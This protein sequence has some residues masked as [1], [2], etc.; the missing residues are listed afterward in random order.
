RLAPFDGDL[1]DYAKWLAE[2]GRAAAVSGQQNAMPAEREAETAESR[3]QRKREEAEYRNRL[4]PLRAA[5]ASAERELERLHAEQSQ[6]QTALLATD[7]YADQSKPR[8]LE[9]LERQ[10]RLAR[11]TQAAETSWLEQTERLEAESRRLSQS[12][13]DD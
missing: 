11:E 3:K 12:T 9:L 7:I 6:V 5:V 1:D 8:L 13:G 4:S 2:A 10:A